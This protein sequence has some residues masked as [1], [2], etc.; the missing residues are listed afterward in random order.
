[1]KQQEL[2]PAVIYCRVSDTKKGKRGD[3]LNSQETRCREFARFGNYEVDQ[4]FR[5]DMTGGTIDRPGMTA[6]VKFLK[7]HRA[8]GY[9]V[10]IDDIDRF[11]RDI[12]G[13]WDLRDLLREAGGRLVSPKMEF[14]DDAD[15]MMVENIH[16]TFAQHFRQKNAEQTLGRMRARVMNGYNVFQAPIGYRYVSAHGQGRVL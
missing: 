3:G 7:K 9:T 5:D 10:L 4:V 12:R 14:K 6:M 1:M 15:S 16:A 2:R 8:L 13:H 11:A